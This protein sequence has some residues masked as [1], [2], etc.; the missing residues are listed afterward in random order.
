MSKIIK[1][2][3]GLDINLEGQAA[4]ETV[5]AP[6]ADSYAVSPLDFEGVT[7]KLLVNVGDRVKAGSALFFNKYMPEI[8]KF[9]AENDPGSEVIGVAAGTEEESFRDAMCSIFHL[10]NLKS[11]NGK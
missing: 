9:L 2:K 6:L 4:C 3:K 8:K 7:P 1:L 11:S 10:F 5:N